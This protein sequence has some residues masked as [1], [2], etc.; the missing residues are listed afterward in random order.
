MFGDA[1]GQ[2]D[3]VFVGLAVGFEFSSVDSPDHR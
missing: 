3:K 1:D 2:G